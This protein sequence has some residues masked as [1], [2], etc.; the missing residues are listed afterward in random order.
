[1]WPPH[2]AHKALGDL[3]GSILG[4]RSM[5]A[6]RAPVTYSLNFI[7]FPKYKKKLIKTP[8]QHSLGCSLK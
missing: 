7:L 3:G 1:M 2:S 6:L 8:M 4:I 5:G